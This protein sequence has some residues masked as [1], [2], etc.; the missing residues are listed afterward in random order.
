MA[1]IRTIPL[2]RAEEPLRG[3]YDAAVK[4]A[5]KVWNIVSLTSLRARVT[6]KSLALYQEIMFGP[7]V[8]TRGERELVATVVSATNECRY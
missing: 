3:L 8:L 6:E 1:W 2:D 5:G 7:S 4:R